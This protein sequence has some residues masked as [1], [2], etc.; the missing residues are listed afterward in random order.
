M[1]RN[2]LE[3]LTRRF[4]ALR[5]LV[6]GDLFLDRWYEIDESLNSPSIE[7][8][9]T[10]YHVARKRSAPGACGTVL[11]NLSAMGVGSLR[12]VSML[13]DDGDGWEMLKRLSERRVETDAVVRSEALVT[14][15]YI[16]PLFP[17]EGNRFD[18]ENLSPTPA[19]IE[20][21]LI[22]RA[23]AELGKA[24][25]VILLDQVATPNTGVLTD[26]VRGYICDW[27]GKHPDK[28]IVAD[29]R[30]TI[31]LYTNVVIKCNNF[32]A[33]NL[34]GRSESGDDFNAQDVFRDLGDIERRT[35]RPA[36]VTCNKHGIA[37]LEAG[38]G[39]LL[40]AA[41]HDG[42]IDICGAGDAC[43]AGFTCAMAA[44]GSCAEAAFIGNL[45][46]GVTVRKLGQTGTASPGEMLALYDEQF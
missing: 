35:G 11:N 2:R 14:P 18:I 32:E 19:A 45:A 37:V 7:T 16:K 20:D 31:G 34:I 10:V 22:E 41:R 29:S 26:R 36:V 13:G 5:I 12:V 38:E 39:R 21:M 8:G 40:P 6:V 44:G 25:A 30:T 27:A 1:D 4:E 9:K 3:E 46:S 33:A 15:S 28:L 23:G 43:T 17:V 24:D 42:P